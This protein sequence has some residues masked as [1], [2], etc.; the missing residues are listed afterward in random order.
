MI[1]QIPVQRLHQIQ[2]DLVAL[3]QWESNSVY[4]NMY[5]H[6]WCFYLRDTRSDSG[7]ESSG[8]MG[9]QRCEVSLNLS[10]LESYHSHQPIGDGSQFASNGADPQR[11]K[12]LL[13][14][15]SCSCGCTIPFKPLYKI[16]VAFWGLP[17]ASQDA[18]LWSLQCGSARKTSWSIEGKGF[19]VLT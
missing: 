7:D 1:A 2:G 19:Q 13:R 10:N 3:N 16:R 11:I 8:S 9:D 15:P 18:V 17:K 12:S 4:S 6:S 14:K 5:V